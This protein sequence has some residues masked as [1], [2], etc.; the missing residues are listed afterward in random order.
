M[1]KKIVDILKNGKDDDVGELEKDIR[2]ENNEKLKEN[3]EKIKENLSALATKLNLDSTNMTQVF[4]DLAIEIDAEKAEKDVIR[5]FE[6]F[7]DFGDDFGQTKSD[8]NFTSILDNFNSTLPEAFLNSTDSKSVHSSLD[9]LIDN[10]E[11]K[12][13]EESKSDS[14]STD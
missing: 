4:D 12:P 13:D 2:E 11:H 1:K 5:D 3:N 8:Q 6:S 9:E 14:V 10:Y 7:G